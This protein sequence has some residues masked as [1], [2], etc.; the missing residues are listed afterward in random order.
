MQI[1]CLQLSNFWKYERS[2]QI[3]LLFI[4]LEKNYND[5]SR[6]RLWIALQM[7]EI[8]EGLIKIKRYI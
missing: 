7:A 1:I 4:D 6:K 2:K 8:N 5:T 3:E